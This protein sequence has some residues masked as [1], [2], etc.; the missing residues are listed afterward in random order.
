MENKIVAFTFSCIILCIAIFYLRNFIILDRN[1]KVEAN[2]L[3]DEFAR[4]FDKYPECKNLS[5]INEKLR[6]Q[7]YRSLPN[8]GEYKTF[9]EQLKKRENEKN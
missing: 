6:N 4:F 2:K 1:A 7:E 5:E 3:A 9:C 8:Y